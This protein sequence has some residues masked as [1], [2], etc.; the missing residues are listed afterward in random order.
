MTDT[1]KFLME[2]WITDGRMEVKAITPF[3]TMADNVETVSASIG[4]KDET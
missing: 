1:T 2:I 3:T 4:G